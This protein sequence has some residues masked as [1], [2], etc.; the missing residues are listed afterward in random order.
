[1]APRA[2]G[3]SAPDARAPNSAGR[4]RAAPPRPTATTTTPVR[5]RASAPHVRTEVVGARRGESGRGEEPHTERARARASPAGG[6]GLRLVHTLGIIH[7]Y[8]ALPL[9]SLGGGRRFAGTDPS[10]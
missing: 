1:M 6:G 9:A 2:L 7:T 8:R 10:P 3:R 4:A 5:T